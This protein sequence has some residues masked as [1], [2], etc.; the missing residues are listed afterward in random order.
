[1]GARILPLLIVTLA[2]LLVIS[3][4]CF[5]VREQELALRV[6]LSRIVRSD[7]AAGAAFQDPVRRGRGQV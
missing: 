7:Y 3:T 4:S 1:M 2:V 5:V 6:Q